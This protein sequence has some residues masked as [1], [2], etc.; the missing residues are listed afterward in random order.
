MRNK[1]L[2]PWSLLAI[3]SIFWVILLA[4]NISFI[5]NNDYV[6]S[7]VNSLISTKDNSATKS[8][9]ATETKT[10]KVL[11]LPTTINIDSIKIN[12]TIEHF[13]ITAKW[14]MDVSKDPS[15]ASRYKIGVR[16]GEIGNA[17]IAWHFGTWKDW[18]KWL[19][20][21]LNKLKKWDK[22]QVVD[23]NWVTITFIVRS[24]KT[25]NQNANTSEIFFSNDNKAHLNLIT[26]E[27]TWDKVSKTYSNRL[28]VFTDKEELK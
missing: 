18:R 3:S 28:V 12:T 11:G 15:I 27:W 25:Y 16:P 1:L 23:E 26:C 19:F 21:N 17:V 14:L 8:S 6:Y 7:K 9:I 22:V 20:N 24:T 5:D 10:M 4:I 13:G 2:L